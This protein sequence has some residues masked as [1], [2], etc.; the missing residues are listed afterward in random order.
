[1]HVSSH[2]FKPLLHTV[3][4]TVRKMNT[5]VLISSFHLRAH[6]VFLFMDCTAISDMTVHPSLTLRV[7]ETSVL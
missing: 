7:A 6:Y 2:Y 1:M 4:S 3:K 5:P